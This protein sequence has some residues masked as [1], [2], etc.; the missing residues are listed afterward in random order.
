LFV[1]DQF[2]RAPSTRFGAKVAAR[3]D[4]YAAV[5]SGP[6]ATKQQAR[7]FVRHAAFPVRD[8]VAR[9]LITTVL[10]VGGLMFVFFA[11]RTLD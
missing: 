6:P 2:S 11:T 7:P 4:A 1:A 5:R 8:A 10:A 9:L 3:I